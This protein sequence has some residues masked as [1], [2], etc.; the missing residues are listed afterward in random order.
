MMAVD[1]RVVSVASIH[2]STN[3]NKYPEF[4]R[5]SARELTR[6]LLSASGELRSN[7]NALLMQ[8]GQFVSHDLAKTTQMNNAEC[9]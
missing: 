7:N 9:R 6:F 4:N 2:P 1:N 8:W 5:P 3:T